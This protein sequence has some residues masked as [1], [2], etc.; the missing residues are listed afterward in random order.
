MGKSIVEIYS[1]S[2]D[3]LYNDDGATMTIWY[4]PTTVIFFFSIYF[5][6]PEDRQDF[7]KNSKRRVCVYFQPVEVVAESPHV[8]DE[9]PLLAARPRDNVR[10]CTV[11]TRVHDNNI[12]VG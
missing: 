7:Y 3:A 11:R 8:R 4:W 6:P 5:F 9:R 2:D 12:V 10:V 1:D